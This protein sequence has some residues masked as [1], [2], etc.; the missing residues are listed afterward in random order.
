MT[1]VSNQHQAACWQNKRFAIG[2]RKISIRGECSGVLLAPF[3]KGGLE[4][5][6]HQ[7][8]PVA[9][10]ASLVFCIDG[11]YRVFAIENRCNVGLEYY[12]GN[13]ARRA[14][15]NVVLRFDQQFQ[16][17]TM[18][19]QQ[20]RVRIINIPTPNELL[21]LLQ[22]NDLSSQQRRLQGLVV[23]G[24]RLNLGMTRV[25]E[26]CRA[27]KKRH[28][29]FDD[30]GAAFRIVGRA[31]FL[32]IGLLNNVGAVQGVIKTSPPGVTGVYC[33]SR[34]IDGNDELWTGNRRYFRID[35]RCFDL[36]CFAFF[37]EV[38]DPEQEIDIL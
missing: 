17:Q 1:H 6:G 5:T 4:L 11:G 18:I 13:V 32:A 25:I 10:N 30:S 2:T 12:I 24:V 36:E 3:F 9:V 35:I 8:K 26:W 7:P 29:V 14:T 16:M 31:A 34:I 20:D 28:S 33:E 22:A 23:Y 37:P 27:I 19:P 15:T 21:R 38:A